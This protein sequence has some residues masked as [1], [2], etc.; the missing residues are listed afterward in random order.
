MIAG[1]TGP[2]G[3]TGAPG[4]GVR[5]IGSVA[6]ATDLNPAESG[7][8]AG[9]GYIVEDTGHLYVFEPGPPPTFVDV[10]HI[11]GPTGPAGDTG[12]GGSGLNGIIG[13]KFSPLDLPVGAS[14]GDAFIVQGDLWVFK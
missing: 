13:E 7:L 3:D 6:T 9:D 1:P 8:Q 10:G 5:I 2:T 14:I 4:V 12:P 11:Q